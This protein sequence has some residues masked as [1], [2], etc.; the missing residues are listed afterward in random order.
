M[1]I[2]HIFLNAFYAEPKDK[3]PRTTPEDL[4]SYGRCFR[5][6]KN[7]KSQC[8]NDSANSCDNLCFHN[9]KIISLKIYGCRTNPAPS[10]LLFNPFIQNVL[11]WVCSIL[12]CKGK[13]FCQ[14]GAAWI[15]RNS[16]HIDIPSEICLFL[17][18][19]NSVHSL[20]IYSLKI[21]DAG[22]ILYPLKIE[23][24]VIP[25]W[26][27]YATIFLHKI[28][29][30]I[31]RVS[32]CQNVGSGVVRCVSFPLASLVAGDFFVNVCSHCFVYL[33]FSVAKLSIISVTPN[34]F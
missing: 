26:G 16:I 34:K 11:V 33:L 5:R 13:C 30:H 19:Y 6:D 17:V 28:R 14:S 8:A 27:R 2:V 32:T 20:K 18:K 10:L 1:F 23:M 21:T 9:L 24:P 7:E 22:L 3:E 29:I 15:K 4:Q 25:L 31:V 12:Y